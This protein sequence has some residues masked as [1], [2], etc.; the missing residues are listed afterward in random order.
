MSD[1]MRTTV[2]TMEA[3]S[4]RVSDVRSEIQGLLSTLKGEVDGVRGGWEGSA[5]IAFQSLMERW[6][7]SA[8]KLNQALEAISENIKSNSVSYDSAQQDHTSSL[9]NVASSLNI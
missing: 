9:N 1:Q 3:T 2:E 5:A 8:N 7:G 4:R 6:D